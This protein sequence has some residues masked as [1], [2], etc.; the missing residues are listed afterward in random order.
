[1]SIPIY[2]INLHS[3]R[4]RRIAY[5]E[6]FSGTDFSPERI[7]AIDSL[8][9][10]QEHFVTKEV[11]ACWLSHQAAYSRLL[12]SGLPYAIIM[13]DD[14]LVNKDTL[15]FLSHVRTLDLNEVDIF[16][17]GYLTSKSRID[18]PTY[19]PFPL[20]LLI[21]RRYVGCWLARFDCIHRNWLRA[22]RFLVRRALPMFY[23]FSRITRIS[24]RQRSSEKFFQTEY[25][26]RKKYNLRHPIIYH[27]IEAGAHA[28]IISRS[29]AEK[30]L[31]FNNP[32]FLP[33]DLALMG[34]GS[35]KNFVVVRTSKSLCGQS[36]SPS[37][38]KNRSV[39]NSEAKHK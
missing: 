5:L 9:V 36:N 37:S 35:S 7:E 17:F 24:V 22:T 1:M 39:L 32:V 38:I 25:L 2:F 27:S 15:K 13:E 10:G 18:F 12:D 14:A 30:L 33:A 34:I 11:A 19:D 20:E 21:L 8:E 6:Q 29:C 31:C 3:R 4:D 26:K 23:E 16:Q 28:Y